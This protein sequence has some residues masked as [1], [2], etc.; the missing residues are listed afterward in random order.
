MELVAQS[1][2]NII[3][4]LAI[5]AGLLFAGWWAIGLLSVRTR[6][7][8]RERPEID[9]PDGLREK[10]NGIPP[11]LMIFLIFTG[12]TMVAYILVTWL[13]GVSY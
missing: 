8:E 12:V 9:A 4:I 2:T 3:A 1:L 10:L 11:V 13:A 6:E 7:Q 5:A